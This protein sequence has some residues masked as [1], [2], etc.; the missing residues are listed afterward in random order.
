MKTH[1]ERGR[2]GLHLV[3]SAATTKALED[4]FDYQVAEGA[5]QLK[6]LQDALAEEALE[7]IPDPDH[8]AQLVK[9]MEVV[10]NWLIAHGVRVRG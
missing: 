1:S 10:R 6:T 4:R 5:L 2:R 3:T 9:Q 8:V 7:E